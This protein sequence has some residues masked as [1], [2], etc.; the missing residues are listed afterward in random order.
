MD[1]CGEIRLDRY[2]NF[3]A[4][5]FLFIIVLFGLY[6]LFTADQIFF[7]TYTH[8]DLVQT[9]LESDVSSR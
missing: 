2:W 9:A 3:I 7:T 8:N 5:P 4:T 1:N 6:T